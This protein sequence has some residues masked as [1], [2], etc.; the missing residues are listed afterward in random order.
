M[1][2]PLQNWKPADFFEFG[3]ETGRKCYDIE[4][5]GRSCTPVLQAYELSLRRRLQYLRSRMSELKHQFEALHSNL[6]DRP[7]PVND[8]RM[9]AHSRKI[10]IVAVFTVLT[11]L[12]CLVGNTA[13]FYLMGLGLAVSFLGGMGMTALPLGIGHLAYEW[14]FSASRWIKMAIVL[15]ALMLAASGIV[16]AGHARRNMVDR[17]S[18]TPVVSSYVDG[19]DA[20]I[21]PA[22]ESLSGEKSESEIYRTL[23]SGIFLFMLAA[24]LGLAFLVGWLIELYGDL[25]YTAWRRLQS[26]RTEL[27]EVE[28]EFVELT[29]APELA[30]RYCLAG[31][32]CAHD[33]RPRRRPPYHQAVTLLL[34]IVILFV[35]PSRSQSIN[36]CEAELIDSSA[37]ISRGGRTNELFHEYLVGVRRLLLTEPSN[38]R[39]WV[40]SISTD[41]F[42]SSHEILKGW[43][44]EARGVF[45][46][47]LSRARLELAS[48]FERKS[49]GMAPAA[50]GTDIF[51]G[52]WRV[53]TLLESCSSPD[54]TVP[55]S[56][57]IWIF[58][59]MMN[60]TKEFPMPSLIE[61]GSQEMLE[62][63]K[64][65]GLLVPLKGYRV[66]VV[67]ATTTGLTPDGW[68]TL[69]LFWMRYFA[70]AGAELVSY[71]PE[72]DGSR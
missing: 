11:G 39:I 60:E 59:D 61:L 5:A 9:L 32:L 66:H 68:E 53:K 56:R 3:Y 41:S 20:D 63:T 31:I 47:E 72:V 70:A 58:S 29:D 52:L 51:G 34:M 19:A 6:Y 1:K 15:V 12:A 69:H 46:D 23:G 43:T 55:A 10:W 33:E 67:G 25:H 38:T 18:S 16:I 28:A 22:R 50:A 26:I 45:T 42:G 8:A 57:T 40:L 49:A 27:S 21:Q 35:L 14:I 36:A 64:A 37:S 13:T 44:P 65:E 54:S 7:N 71:S 30:K 62:R 17:S 2:R 48:A 24:E 4:Q